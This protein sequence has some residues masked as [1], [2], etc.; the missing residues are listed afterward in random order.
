MSNLTPVSNKS[1]VEFHLV[2]AGTLKNRLTKLGKDSANNTLS[3]AYYTMVNGNAAP[4]GNC[5]RSISTLL[6]PVY[7]QFVC[8]K[9][10]REKN[11]WTYAKD[12]ATKLLKSLGI[13]FNNCSF[14]DFIK[15]VESHEQTKAAK[16]A[17]AEAQ[18]EALSP[19]EVEAKEKDKVLKYLTRTNLTV[20]QLKDLVNLVERE[21]SQANAKKVKAVSA[22]A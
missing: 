21:R 12:K 6:H 14:E 10:D 8:A 13:E 15:A 9:W 1:T 3:L 5:D 20:T 19:T 22:A 2:K 17:D 18:A 11:Q 7:R 4:L 16:K